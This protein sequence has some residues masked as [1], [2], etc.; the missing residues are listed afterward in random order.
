MKL[1]LVTGALIASGLATSY[2]DWPA[3]RGPKGT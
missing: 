2:G 3:W 1:T